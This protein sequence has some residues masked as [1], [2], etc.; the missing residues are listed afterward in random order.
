MKSIFNVVLVG[1]G[2]VQMANKYHQM[3]VQEAGRRA[4]MASASAN[5][6]IKF[7]SLGE[8]ADYN[9]AKRKDAVKAKA[10]RKK[11]GPKKRKL[12]LAP[13]KGLPTGYDQ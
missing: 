7:T 8:V 13:R 10:Q 4:N 1:N 12:K 3:A 11:Y 2:G 6:G 9:A 5:A